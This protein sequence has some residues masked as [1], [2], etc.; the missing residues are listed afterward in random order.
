MLPSLRLLLYRI[1]PG[2]R[3]DGADLLLRVLSVDWSQLQLWVSCWLHCP[4]PAARLGSPVA[5]L[6]VVPVRWTNSQE[7]PHLDTH[8]ASGT[9][10]KA[11]GVH[12]PAR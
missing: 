6:P 8:T 3:E 4:V 10:Q 7:V 11:V 1:S 5:E 2:C 9:F 12:A